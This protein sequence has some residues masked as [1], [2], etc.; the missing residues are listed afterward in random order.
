MM[1]AFEYILTEAFYLEAGRKARRC[2]RG[3]KY[4]FALKVCLGVILVGLVAFCLSFRAYG[5]A[6]TLGVFL[7]LLIVGRRLDERVNQWRLRKSPFFNES[8]RIE[9]YED[10]V[11]LITSKSKSQ[12]IWSVF[13]KARRFKDGFMLFQGGRASSWL[14]INTMVEGTDEE[15]EQLLRSRIPDY[16]SI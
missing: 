16:K 6:A 4:V 14:P 5:S 2:A 10:E 8:I 11:R 9:L 13:T 3:I 7:V 15:T 12:A 1:T